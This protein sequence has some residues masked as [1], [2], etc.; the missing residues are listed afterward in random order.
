MPAPNNPARPSLAARLAQE[1]SAPSAPSALPAQT[2]EAP[3]TSALNPKP[4]PVSSEGWAEGFTKD[5]LEAAGESLTD[6]SPP[7]LSFLSEAL[8]AHR[9][10][11]HVLFSRKEQEPSLNPAS[12]DQELRAIHEGIRKG[13]GLILV[14]YQLLSGEGEP[15]TET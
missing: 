14:I 8:H 9:A 3:A 12:K 7:V 6:L 4:T 10:T 13:E 15:T 2:V 11:L 5:E 1:G